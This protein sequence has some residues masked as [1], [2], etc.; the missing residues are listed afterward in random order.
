MLN[1]AGT[2]L[3][4]STAHILGAKYHLVHG[5]AVAY[6][7]PGVLELVNETMPTKSQRDRGKFW[8]SSLH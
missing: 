7:L 2:N 5:E 4:H 6:A 8:V 3:G 1:N